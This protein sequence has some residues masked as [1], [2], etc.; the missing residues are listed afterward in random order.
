MVPRHGDVLS[1]GRCRPGIGGYDGDEV[2]SAFLRDPVAMVVARGE[3]ARGRSGV[4][5]RLWVEIG[6]TMTEKKPTLEYESKQGPERRLTTCSFCGCTNKETGPQVEWP[7]HVFQCARCVDAA[8]EVIRR[9][10]ASGLI[11]G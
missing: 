6:A 2:W 1:A 10:R 11:P 3:V 7:N 8:A 5:N 9:G 4:A